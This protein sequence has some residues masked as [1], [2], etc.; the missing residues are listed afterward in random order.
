MGKLLLRRRT[1]FE[2]GKSLFQPPAKISEIG[3][4]PLVG[5]EIYRFQ[6]LELIKLA[7]PFRWWQLGIVHKNDNHPHLIWAT[8]DGSADFPTDVVIRIAE[9][10]H[11]VHFALITIDFVPPWADQGEE[12]TA[13]FQLTLQN[14]LPLVAG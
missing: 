12:N 10:R 7:I 11:A 3:V 2:L 5:A 9:P 13:F 14:L 6:V 8:P 1:L 4:E